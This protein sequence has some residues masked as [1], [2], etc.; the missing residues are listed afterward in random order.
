MS[1][2]ITTDINVEEVV[3]PTLD[4]I[5]QTTEPAEILEPATDLPEEQPEE[6]VEPPTPLEEEEIKPPSRRETLRIQQILAKRDAPANP[7]PEPFKVEDQLD[8]NSVLDADPE[9]INK[10]QADRQRSSEQSYN[11]GLKTAEYLNWNTSL[12]IDSPVVEKKYPILDKRSEQF[13][14]AVANAVN[15]W[16]LRMAGYDADTKTVANPDVGYADF[17]ESYM[18][19]VE[20]TAGVKNAQSAKNIATQAANTALRPDGSTAKALNLNRDPSEMTLEELY[21][22][23]GQKPPTK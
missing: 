12:K 7:L 11:Q 14:P 22:A 5:P 9:T 1:D 19:L 4:A 15:S 17:V 3:E 2:P 20:E 8:Y 16:Y 23:M 6:I 21:A 13:H 18:E 10:F